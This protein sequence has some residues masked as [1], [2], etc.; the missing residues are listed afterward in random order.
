MGQGNAGSYS[1]MFLLRILVDA[2]PWRLAGAQVQREVRLWVRRVGRLPS[3]DRD[4]AG[5]PHQCVVPHGPTSRH[6]LLTGRNRRAVL[7]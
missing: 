6:R 4:P 2:N 7:F 3:D 1:W 5:F